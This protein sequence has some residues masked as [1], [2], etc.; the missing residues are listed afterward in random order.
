MTL[1][2]L[3]RSLNGLKRVVVITGAGVSAESGIDTFRGAGGHWERYRAEDLASPAGFAA[4]PALVWRWYDARRRRILAASPNPAHMALAA[5][6][7][8]FPVFDLITQNV[9]GLHQQAGSENVLELH[10][11]IW[12]LRCS[13]S[14]KEWINR[15]VFSDF[16]VYC[17]C[18]ALA[19]PAVLWFGETYSSPVLQQAYHAVRQAECILVVGT[20]GQVWIVAGLLA[21]ATQARIAEFNLVPSR[22]SHQ[23]DWLIEGPAGSHLPELLRLLE[24]PQNS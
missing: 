18:G 4:D 24:P 17:A 19:R 7:L 11:S 15:E 21:E 8:R 12:R 13:R 9:D 6:A 5:L 14:G 10:G 23:V 3:A 1:E 16:P 2:V 20:S 22:L